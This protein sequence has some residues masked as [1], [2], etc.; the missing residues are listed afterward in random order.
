[1]P[2][3]QSTDVVRAEP[4]DARRQVQ[5]A[6]QS[7]ATGLL[8]VLHTARH[9]YG[10][11]WTAAE[12]KRRRELCNAVSAVREQATRRKSE[13]VAPA[14]HA[15]SNN[16]SERSER[17]TSTSHANAASAKMGRAAAG[18]LRAS[19]RFSL[20]QRYQKP[21]RRPAMHVLMRPSSEQTMGTVAEQG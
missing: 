4:L 1:M 7:S 19:N 2:P 11:T 15:N 16:S 17:L 3:Q 8:V 18:R 13:R 14:R 6:L 5:Q 21:N 10:V 9:V 20:I 12:R